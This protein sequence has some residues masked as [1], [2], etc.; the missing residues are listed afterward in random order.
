MLLAI[1]FDTL[2]TISLSLLVGFAGTIVF[3]P[4]I[5]YPGL[6]LN[7]GVMTTVVGVIGA[8][9]GKIISARAKNPRKTKWAA[10]IIGLVIGS[11]IG[12]CLILPYLFID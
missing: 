12:I 6:I 8:F 10:A 7:P 3:G 9:I 4:S 1:I 11:A 2:P 5:D